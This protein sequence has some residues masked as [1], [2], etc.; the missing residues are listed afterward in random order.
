MARF[1][2]ALIFVAACS[3]FSI[4][5]NAGL[6]FCNNTSQPLWITVGWNMQDNWVARGWYKIDSGE[7]NP[8][9]DG[10]LQTR[11]YYYYA[12][13]DNGKLVWSGDYDSNGAH[14]C[15]D[16]WSAFYYSDIPNCSGLIYKQVD[17]GQEFNWIVNFSESSD[18][19]QAAVDCRNEMSRGTDAFAKC[20]MRRVSTERQRR[21]LDCWERAKT[22]AGFAICAAKDNMSADAYK[23]ANC[24]EVYTNNNSGSDLA[25]CLA[26]G[27]L[28]ADN[29]R[30]LECVL[31]VCPR[32]Y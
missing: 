22:N 10:P 24:V 27:N 5:A 14:F 21:I 15:A 8:L 28:S 30:L 26:K 9:F 1:I 7:C 4:P 32:T 19:L 23:V 25:Q 16:E 6:G 3:S 18:P 17:T 31:S 11:Y 29:E 13:N 2:A 20:W 12:K